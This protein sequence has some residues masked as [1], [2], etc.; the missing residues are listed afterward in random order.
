MRVQFLALFSPH[1]FQPKGLA[2]LAK[3]PPNSN[4]ALTSNMTSAVFVQRWRDEEQ[5]VAKGS[6]PNLLNTRDGFR[7]RQFIHGPGVGGMVLG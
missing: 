5:L 3:Y 7:R 2:K 1:A 6:V 4:L